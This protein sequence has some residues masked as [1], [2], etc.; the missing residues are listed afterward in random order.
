MINPLKQNKSNKLKKIEAIKDKEKRR[1]AEEHLL[2]PESI[3]EYTGKHPVHKSEVYS[4][5]VTI[6]FDSKE[7]MEMVGELFSIRTSVK[8]LSYITDISLLVWLSKQVK[9]G[10]L[11]VKGGKIKCKKKRH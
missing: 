11:T 8:G 7:Q 10:K 1:T 9:K 2:T 4:R 5:A 3:P 6:V